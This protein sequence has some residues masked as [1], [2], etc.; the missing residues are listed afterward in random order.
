[1]PVKQKLTANRP[2]SGAFALLSFATTVCTTP[3]ASGVHYDD[4]NPADTQEPKQAPTPALSAQVLILSI[5][6]VIVLRCKRDSNHN[7]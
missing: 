1:M 4:F 7:W 5:F 6:G 2:G 3:W